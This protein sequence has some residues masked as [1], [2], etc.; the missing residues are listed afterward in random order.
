[1]FVCSCL[2]SSVVFFRLYFVRRA[3]FVSTLMM[4]MSLFLYAVRL[5]CWSVCGSVY[6]GCKLMLCV[7]L[8]MLMLLLL[9]LSLFILSIVLYRTSAVMLPK[10]LSW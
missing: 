2:V 3:S 4:M 10:L 6:V 9:F 1:M 7:V 5:I 8:L